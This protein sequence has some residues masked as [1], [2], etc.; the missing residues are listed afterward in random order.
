MSSAGLP[1]TEHTKSKYKVQE[2]TNRASPLT[3]E[4]K[5]NTVTWRQ[6]TFPELDPVLT[7]AQGGN[8]LGVRLSNCEEYL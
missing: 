1:S 3:T 6:K 7:S 8:N 5:N 2:A 4:E